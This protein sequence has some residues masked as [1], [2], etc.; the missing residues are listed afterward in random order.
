MTQALV[1]DR[2]A[3]VQLLIDNN[4]NVENI[5]KLDLYNSFIDNKDIK[6]APFIHYLINKKQLP[7]LGV[8]FENEEEL[9]SHIKFL[10][11]DQTQISY[12]RDLI[13]DK[14]IM[15]DLF[16]WSILFNRV[17]IAKIILTIAN[18]FIIINTRK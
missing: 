3:F 17:E 6:E 13:K 5:S 2:P 15:I 8:K 10:I 18:V 16:I 11:R 14:D 12:E 1:C 9:L 4:I 7:K